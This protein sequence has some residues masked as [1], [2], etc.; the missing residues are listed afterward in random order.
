MSIKPAA[1]GF[2]WG[3]C[4][5]KLE[6][7]MTSSQPVSRPSRSPWKQPLGA[8][9]RHPHKLKGEVDGRPDKE[10]AHC[11]DDLNGRLIRLETVLDLALNRPSPQGICLPEGDLGGNMTI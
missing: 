11:L 2:R 1:G 9:H 7:P 8:R 4:S 6:L 10:T 5:V 3:N